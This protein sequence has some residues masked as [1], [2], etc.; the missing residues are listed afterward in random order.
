MG[1]TVRVVL[2][3]PSAERAERGRQAAF[4]VMKEV[5]DR[6]SDF[7]PES[8]LSRLNQAAGKG[9][10]RVS[11]PLLE[12]LKTS[13][14]TADVSGGAFDVTVGPLVR[15][16]RRSRKEK[17][18]P[19]P[20]ELAE[21]RART[22]AENLEIAGDAVALK[23]DGMAIDLGGIAKGYACDRALAALKELG[24]T[25]ALIDAGGGMALGDPPP[26]KPG[27]RIGLLGDPSRILVLKNCG[28]STA[29]DVEQF[30]E[31]DGK[32]YSHIIDPATG[33]GLTNQAMAT[34]I[35]PT[36]LLSDALDTPI[37]VLGPERG[38]RMASGVAGVEAWTQWIEDGRRKRAETP[39][40]RNFAVPAD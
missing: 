18:L 4:A 32:R 10:Q 20:E 5:D 2:Y 30:V 1:T 36:G 34:V 9:P 23:K 15:L 7:K 16:W 37:C 25:R 33:L 24:L 21:A 29:G 27:W 13:A 39:G 40:F 6:M 38:F 31:I 35:A 14:W 26:D 8:E 11:P 17:R 19:T 22:G 3:A 28:V 12:V